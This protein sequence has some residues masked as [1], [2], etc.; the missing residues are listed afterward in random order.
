MSSRTTQNVNTIAS[1]IISVSVNIIAIAAVIMCIYFLA[2]WSYNFG[3]AIFD[4]SPVDAYNGKNVIV[5]VPQNAKL[6]DV[7]RLM[8]N[9]GVVKD[10]YVFMIQI[11]LSDEK[12]NI[13]P[14]TY[15]LS[16]SM[17]PTEII[18]IIAS[19]PETEE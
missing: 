19:D 16:T 10:E 1:T 15:T 13:V 18:E 2:N 8:K 3:N 14:G 11:I 6:L 5:T 12:D 9:A 7:S 4:S 17:M